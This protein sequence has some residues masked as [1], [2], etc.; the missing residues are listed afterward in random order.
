MKSLLTLLII[1]ITCFSVAQ[2]SECSFEYRHYEGI[3]DH[4]TAVMD[5]TILN[6]EIKGTVV[7]PQRKYMHGEYEITYAER[8]EGELDRYEVAT[9]ASYPPQGSSGEYSGTFDEQYIGTYRAPGESTGKAFSLAENYDGS[10]V[11]NGFCI[12]RDTVLMDTIDAPQAHLE[13]TMLLPYGDSVEY[14]RNAILEVYFRNDSLFGSPDDEL[15]ALYCREYFTRYIESNIDIYDGGHAFNWEMAGSTAISMNRSG[16][17]VY[18][19]D[20]YAYSG[21]AHGLGISRFLVFDTEQKRKLELSDL[22]NDESMRK[23][24]KLLEENYRETHYLD[25]EPLSE[26][27]LFED[28]IAPSPNFWITESSISFFYNPYELAPYAMGSITITLPKNK[29]RELLKESSPLK[30]LGW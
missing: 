15:L 22:F 17:L 24:G 14:I 21:G 19:A 11:F 4:D 23:L 3:V 10:I 1:M 18:R 16:L 6:G 2:E 25:D 12:D 9:L 20:N 30:R 8:L 26:A 13:L 27:G 5:L 29:I 7:Y 28:Y